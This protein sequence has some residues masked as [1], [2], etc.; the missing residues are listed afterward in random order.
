MLI[1]QDIIMDTF[2]AKDTIP[3]LK[4]WIRGDKVPKNI[5]LVYKNKLRLSDIC[6]IINDISTSKVEIEIQ[7]KLQGNNYYG[8]GSLIEELN[9]SLKGLRE[10][11]SEVMSELRD[12]QSASSRKGIK[13]Q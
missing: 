11:I 3:I 7:N 4:A 5:N 9:F 1:H 13:E 2:Y 6:S 8:N 10:G 12:L